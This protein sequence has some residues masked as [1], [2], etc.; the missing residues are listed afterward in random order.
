MQLAGG[1]ID[2]HRDTGDA[3]VSGGVQA[4][5]TEQPSS[6][7]GPSRKGGN[8]IVSLGGEGPVHI[9]ADHAVLRRATNTS[10]FYGSAATNARMWQ[11]VNS[12]MAPVLEITRTPQTLKAYGGAG[13]SGAVVFANFTSAMGAR[14]QV[15]AV[16]VSSE[17]LFYSDVERRGDFRGDVTAQD[18]D[19]TIHADEAEI[20]LSPTPKP[21]KNQQAQLERIVASGHIVI[22]QPGRKGVGERLVYTADDGRYVLSGLPEHPPYLEDATKG[23]TFG[24]TLIFNSQNDS[25]VV[26]GGKSSAVTETRAPR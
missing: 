16:R 26:S 22:T 20:Y 21:G 10:I 13:S 25:V 2:Y 7:T 4:V 11:G 17:T 14:R 3:A 1:E 18:P 8:P 23:R 6:V 24:D 15:S 5:Y 9:T 12:I 19:G